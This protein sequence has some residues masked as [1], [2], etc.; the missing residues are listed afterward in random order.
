M[1]LRVEQPSSLTWNG[2]FDQGGNGWE[3]KKPAHHRPHGLLKSVNRHQRS[4]QR[5]EHHCGTTDPPV[6]MP[7]PSTQGG[8]IA[9]LIVLEDVEH[10]LRSDVASEPRQP[11]VP[12]GEITKR[13]GWESA[14]HLGRQLLV[15]ANCIF[16]AAQ[17]ISGTGDVAGHLH[18][19]TPLGA[20]RCAFAHAHQGSALISLH[21]GSCAS[22]ARSNPA[23]SCT[24]TH[25]GAEMRNGLRPLEGWS[26]AVYAASG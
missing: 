24:S 2:Y 8:N 7:R 25:S 4:R 15:R 12:C 18:H 3:R 21:R 1:R 5:Q 6:L 13:H 22:A 17:R 11:R 26:E 20:T 19:A 23:F 14:R 9:C 10:E 16:E